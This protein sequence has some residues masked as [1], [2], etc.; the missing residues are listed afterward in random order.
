MFF[1]YSDKKSLLGE[2]ISRRIDLDYLRVFVVL[3]VLY[4]HSII[5]YAT[6]AY[7]NP[8]NPI[9]TFSPVVN[10]Q[11]LEFFDLI[12]AYNDV[13]FMQLMFFISGLF[14]W[15]S[16]GKKGIKN[17][18][19]N[20]LKR[21]GIPFII[22]VPIIV[23]LA[24]Y[25][26]VLE[27]QLIYGGDTSY[28]DFWSHMIKNGFSTAGPLWFL[29]V[30]LVF[31]FIAAV[32]YHLIPSAE[33]IIKRASLFFERPLLFFMALLGITTL[34]YLPILLIFDS[35]Q[36]IGIGPFT[37]QASR[38]LLYLVYF[39]AGTAVGIYGL[40]SKLFRAD[41]PLAKRWWIWLNGSL[42]IFAAYI[43][44]LVKEVNI[45]ALSGLIFTISC[46][47]IIMSTIGFFIKYAN[48]RFRI[49]DSLSSNAYGIYIIHYLFV[50]W[51][52]YAILQNKLSPFL[53]G[54]FVFIGT[55]LLSWIIIAAIRLI[56]QV[57]KI[58]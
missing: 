1:K 35:Q 55:L 28:M 29:W 51:L 24:Y 34:S 37:V 21:L 17:F 31:D 43:I 30:L 44:I 25:P 7:I 57:K 3:L 40:D 15:K 12:I 46:A 9:A 20:R 18:L 26:A 47:A 14:V 27:V 58:I 56:P 49:L 5:A 45:P 52:Q 48:R 42:L 2:A 53:K 54:N 32:L 39:L 4:H 8:E 10:E 6:F 13:Y 33:H 36:W 50:N 22:C 38:I 11:R 23:P 19:V 16:L 41:G